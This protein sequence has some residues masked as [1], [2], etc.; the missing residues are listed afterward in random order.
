MRSLL[1][2]VLV[3]CASVAQAQVHRCPLG[4][5]WVYS[6]RPC[7]KPPTKI[8][9]A[10]PL[11]SRDGQPVRSASQYTNEVT[12][13]PDYLSRMSPRCAAL[14]DALRTARSRGI[15]AATQAETRR[16]YE[17]ECQDDENR[18]RSELTAERREVSQQQ[19]LQLRQQ[20][21]EADR[22]ALHCASLRDVIR[23]R[24]REAAADE[25]LLA[26]HRQTYA[27]RCERRV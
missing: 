5:R 3:L 20:K 12:R 14:N 1:L 16:N 9:A 6:D 15:S 11:V 2:G 25:K 4:D 17:L 27:E 7:E 10:G 19:A 23:A 24:A 18:A 22:L 21:A 26:R 8:G 13:A